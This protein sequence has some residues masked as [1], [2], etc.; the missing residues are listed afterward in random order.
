MSEAEP[1]RNQG[2]EES[3]INSGSIDRLLDSISWGQRVPIDERVVFAP[4]EMPQDISAEDL[5]GNWPGH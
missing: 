3:E 2:N 5:G 1:K 4:G